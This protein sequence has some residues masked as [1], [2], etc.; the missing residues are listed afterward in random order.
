[1][2]FN[3]HNGQQKKKKRN[4]GCVKVGVIQD[5]AGFEC[6]KFRK[7]PSSKAYLEGY[8]RLTNRLVNKKIHI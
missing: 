1:M 7:C 5:G 6:E 3:K 2:S 8:N 4:K